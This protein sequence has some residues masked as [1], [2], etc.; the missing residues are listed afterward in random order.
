MLDKI[1]NLFIYFLKKMNHTFTLTF[2]ETAENH[3]G[4]QKIG[5]LAQRGFTC[6]ELL[7]IKKNLESKFND[8]KIEYIKCNDFLDKSINAEEASILIIRNGLNFI[9]N[10]DL[11]YKEQLDL[12]KDDKAFMYGRVVN[13]LARHNLCFAD[14]DQEADFINKK[15]T[16][17]NFKNLEFLNECRKNLEVYFG[18]K[19]K[20][21]YAEGN[22]YY[23]IKKCGIGFHGDAER[24]IVIGIRL[25]KTLPLHF[26]WFIESKEI[27]ERIKLT[28]NHGDIY[29]MS[30]K[31]TGND[32]KKRKIFT[33]R[34]AA[35][36]EKFLTIK[37]KK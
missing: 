25:G 22:Y 6:E 31:A 7:N 2:C 10:I 9:S 30:E 34:H 4:M 19:A 12:K 14:I 3:V 13:K 33:L 36:C 28:L 20:N 11:I 8:I 37:N 29:I 1:D 23:D 5:S 32:W 26:Q 24:K 17:I 18:D 35:G 15:G 27:G 21:L 16:I